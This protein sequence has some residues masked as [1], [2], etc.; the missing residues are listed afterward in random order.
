MTAFLNLF[1]FETD[2]SN[3]EGVFN[4]PKLRGFRASSLSTYD[5]C[6]LCTTLSHNF[7]KKKLID[8]IQITFQSEGSP[9]N[10]CNVY[11]RRP[12]TV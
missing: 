5:V 4:K 2:S 10:A 11:F 3:S 9:C 8:L 1:G 12:G 6:T 7:I